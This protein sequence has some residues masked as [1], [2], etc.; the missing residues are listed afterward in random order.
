MLVGLGKKRRGPNWRV[1][2]GLESDGIGRKQG[3]EGEES[4]S[5]HRRA[6]NTRE[7]VLYHVETGFSQ[8]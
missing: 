5:C 3:K 4:A 1:Y 7:V 6:L 2:R 8:C